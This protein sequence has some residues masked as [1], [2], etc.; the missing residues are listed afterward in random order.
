MKENLLYIRREAPSL[1]A[2]EKLIE[3]GI[4]TSKRSSN[5]KDRLDA[6]ELV[7]DIDY[8]LQDVLQP[9]PQGGYSTKKVYRRGA[10]SPLATVD[11]RSFQRSRQRRRR[12]APVL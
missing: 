1:K 3:Y 12:V 5:V 6:L 11:S 10:P 8:R 2:T 7:E 9:V 4:V